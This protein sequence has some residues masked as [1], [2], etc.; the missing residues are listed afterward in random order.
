MQT[1]PNAV[2]QIAMNLLHNAAK[3][4]QEGQISFHASISKEA[5]KEWLKLEISDTGVGIPEGEINRI[6][7]PFEKGT[8]THFVEDGSGLGLSIVD[9]L[10]KSLG[11]TINLKSSPGKGSTFT[12]RIPIQA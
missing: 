2:F 5:Q 11:G 10:L 7:I 4:T 3:F 6:L 8:S 9:K 1:D 12:V